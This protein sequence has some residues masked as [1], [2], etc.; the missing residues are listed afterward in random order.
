MTWAHWGSRR[1]RR[2]D[3]TSLLLWR[4]SHL[5]RASS[6][7]G[8]GSGG[9][10]SRPAPSFPSI[11]GVNSAED[12]TAT[13]DAAGT[14]LAAVVS[15]LSSETRLPPSLVPPLLALPS[16]A[17]GG[18]AVEAAAEGLLV[19]RRNLQRGLLPPE[20][21]EWPRDAVFRTAV[22][23][24]FADLDM[25]R[26]TR[27]HPAL[28]DTVLANVLDL[29]AKY[30]ANRQEVVGPDGEGGDQEQERSSGSKDSGGEGDAS[31][32]G[33]GDEEEQPGRQGGGGRS[34]QQ[35]QGEPRSGQGGGQAGDDMRA[36]MEQAM[37]GAEFAMEAQQSQQEQ[38]GADASS[39]AAQ[40]NEALAQALAK[41][42]KQEWDPLTQHVDAAAKAFDGFDLKDLAE[43]QRGFDSS[44][45]LWHATGWQELDALRAKL[46]RLR[47]LRDLVRSLGR[48][49]GRGPRRRAPRQ[50]ERQRAPM[51][52]VRSEEAP[53]ETRGLTRS[54]DLSR[55]L[56]NEST[57]LAASRRGMPAARLLHF[58]R[59]AE[60]T[61]LSYERVG[62]VDTPAVTTHGMEVR[63]AAECGPILVCLDTSG[64][65]AGAR[66]TVAK[67]LT[68]E[69]MRQAR[70][71]QRGC[72]A[73]AFSG[74]GQCVEFEL[75]FTARG[76][77]DLLKFLAGSFHGGTDVD[78]P[79]K[80]SLERLQ[81][82]PEWANADVLL[83]TDGE[84]P[85]P[86]DQL[87]ASLAQATQD[88]GLKVHGLLVGEEHGKDAPVRQLCT[89]VTQFS[90]WDNLKD[91][92]PTTG[93]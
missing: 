43:G 5:A 20:D 81:G 78:E 87:L 7:D 86:S 18:G 33:E 57:L 85:A 76:M 35:Q 42:F 65:M 47:E 37:A 75:S 82:H 40:A 55:M 15:R 66:E 10:D 28:L 27:R 54:D 14:S 91:K 6:Q 17:A 3:D 9:R 16:T 24:V 12:A 62:W 25:A 22:L 26:F 67:A 59:R 72:Y 93:R 31:E 48:G 4:S 74:P 77:T 69:C 23:G 49:G 46:Q 36:A 79:L 83:V 32:G 73:Y 56:P 80:R 29:L 58:A 38:P 13:L 11:Q 2:A 39:S 34:E 8:D 64:S 41:E 68:L 1:V 71:Q 60:R 50:V 92:S 88:M 19:W 84:I 63:P 70:V 52:L 45:G 61:L 21:V 30:E 51:G 89:H 90:A 44:A 53:E